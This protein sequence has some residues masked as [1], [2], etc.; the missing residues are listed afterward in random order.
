[1]LCDD[2]RDDF[3]DFCVCLTKQVHRLQMPE[4]ALPKKLPTIRLTTRSSARI[5]HQQQQT[6]ASSAPVVDST[7]LDEDDPSEA[8]RG[9]SGKGYLWEESYKR[10]WD[11]LEEDEDG[12]LST[13]VQGLAMQKRRRYRYLPFIHDDD[14]WSSK[15]LLK[16][17]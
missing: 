8:L 11:V 14:G 4:E 10:S 5:Q 12:S 1:V 7:T 6:K 13:V 3:S 16:G 9:K 15:V 17:D 2:D